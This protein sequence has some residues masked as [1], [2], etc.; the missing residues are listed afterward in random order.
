MAKTRLEI[1]N[2][3]RTYSRC[4]DKNKLTLDEIYPYLESL[5]NNLEIT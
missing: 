5:I 3:F 4:R 1:L 2:L